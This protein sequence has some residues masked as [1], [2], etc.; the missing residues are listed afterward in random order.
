MKAKLKENKFNLLLLFIFF[1]AWQ[2][3]ISPAK[4]DQ[5]NYYNIQGRDKYD[6]SIRTVQSYHTNDLIIAS[7]EVYADALAAQNLNYPVL[8]V[9]G[10]SLSVEARAEVGRFSNIHI[11]GGEN[12]VS[13][14]IVKEIMSINPNANIKRYAGSNRYETALELQAGLSLNTIVLASGEHY[15][16]ALAGSSLAKYINA[17]V[18]LTPKNNLYPALLEL[19]KNN[20]SKVY[21]LGGTSTISVNV[22]SQLTNLSGVSVERIAGANRYE[23]ANLI[24]AKVPNPEKMIVVTGTT[25]E[26]ALSA[27]IKLRTYDNEGEAIL[28]LTDSQAKISNQESQSLNKYKQTLKEITFVGDVNALPEMYKYNVEQIPVT[29]VKAQ[30]A[31][32]AAPENPN[33]NELIIKEALEQAANS[34]SQKAYLPESLD[35][36]GGQV[37]DIAR[38]VAKGTYLESLHIYD[39]M[40][41]DSNGIFI[42]I[43]HDSAKTQDYKLIYQEI[44][45]YVNQDLAG[46]GEQ[47][48]AEKIYADLVKHSKYAASHEVANVRTDQGYD[49]YDPYSVFKSGVG[50]CEA[51]S[52]AYE[53]I[54]NAAGLQVRYI[55]NS[56]HAWNQVN[57]GGNWYGL[58]ITYGVGLTSQGTPG[59]M[60][61]FMNSEVTSRPGSVE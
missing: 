13:N 35:P 45:A 19:I 21:I 15:A 56:N 57:I 28:H 55:G 20:T 23:T 18:L 25:Y 33:Q 17:P 32:A 37:A 2:L 46:L 24:N 40:H 6:T 48:R 39:G 38:K 54:A 44:Y 22:E 27:S 43:R 9:N 3:L 53:M 49:P 7:G 41:V 51:F 50:V 30:E 8:L 5:I 12:T 52:R 47:A 26:D 59:N 58:D 10:N 31:L 36:L 60:S 14:N 16:D 29:G 61:W 42:S 4:A 11:A 1:F 34:G